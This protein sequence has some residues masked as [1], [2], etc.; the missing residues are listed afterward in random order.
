MAE[1]K[2]NVLK[3]VVAEVNGVLKI[4]VARLQDV[5]AKKEALRALGLNPAGATQVANVPS[6]VAGC[7][8][9]TSWALSLAA[10]G[11]AV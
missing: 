10:A 7:S 2:K 1:P 6:P 4:I 11:W 3:S 8:G 5:E 9:G